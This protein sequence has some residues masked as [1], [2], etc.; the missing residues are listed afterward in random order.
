MSTPDYKVARAEK[1]RG[2]I[3]RQVD[4]MMTNPIQHIDDK[5]TRLD[6][7]VDRVWQDVHEWNNIIR[8]LKIYPDEEYENAVSAGDGVLRLSPTSRK[9]VCK[10]IAG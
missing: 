5:I 2:K 9:R 1:R 8:Y 6:E 7:S 3:E 4:I 10:A